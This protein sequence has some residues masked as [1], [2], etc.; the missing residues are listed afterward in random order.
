MQ[1]VLAYIIGVALPF[2]GFVGTLGPPV[3]QA[4]E[5]L[6]YLGWMLSFCIS[7]VV[8]YVLCLIWPTQNQRLVREMGLGWEEMSTRTIVAEDGTVI[9]E[10][11]EGKKA[12]D[13]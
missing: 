1:A 9:P 7:F 2:P 5:D 12:F 11:L 8:Y 4:A 13:L 10:I 6:G 3:T